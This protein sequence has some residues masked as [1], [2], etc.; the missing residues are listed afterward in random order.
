MGIPQI[1][2][3]EIGFPLLVGGVDHECVSSVSYRVRF[4]DTETGDFLPTRGLR[5][6]DPSSPYLFL[7]VA[8]GLASLLNKEV[9]T[10]LFSP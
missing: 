3:V 8:D 1:D 7:F 10:D 6:G 2:D 9:T 5:Q 4:N